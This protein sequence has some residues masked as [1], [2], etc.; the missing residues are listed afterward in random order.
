LSISSPSADQ[1][2]V[3]QTFQLPISGGNGAG[4]LVV[5][6][7]GSCTSSGSSITV[8]A[9]GTCA[10]SAYKAGAGAYAVATMVI[11]SP[12][13]TTPAFELIDGSSGT[14]ITWAA[15]TN[16]NRIVSVSCTYPIDLLS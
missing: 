14:A 7:S 13:G 8:S 10:I 6:V 5:S 1:L 11:S 3:G 15:F 2:K 16:A 12:A 4:A 9:P